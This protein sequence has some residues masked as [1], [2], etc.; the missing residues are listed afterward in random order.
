VESAVRVARADRLRVTVRR[1][2]YGCPVVEP[3]G[4]VD[5]STRDQLAEQLSLAL[6]VGKPLLFLDLRGLTFIDS[7][8]VHVIRRTLI[9]MVQGRILAVRAPAHI[10]RIVEFLGLGDDLDFLDVLPGE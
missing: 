5:F 2:P 7:A 1:G 4:E 6:S 3:V 9:R 10:Q 8:G